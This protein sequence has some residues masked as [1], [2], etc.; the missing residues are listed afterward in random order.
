[1][2][3]INDS[4]LLLYGSSLVGTSDVKLCAG[5]LAIPPL[6]NA[7]NRDY[8]IIKVGYGT[9]TTSLNQLQNNLSLTVR[10]N[11]A[12]DHIDISGLPPASYTINTYSL[13]G[14]LVMSN[15]ITSDLSLPLSI[16]SLQ[17]GMYLSNIKNEKINTT[18]RWVKE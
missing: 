10:P 3:A 2:L 14:R 4:T 18:V 11:P 8:W 7:F 1:M 6:N 13:D 9:A 17:S 5:H 16:E 12:K 15:I